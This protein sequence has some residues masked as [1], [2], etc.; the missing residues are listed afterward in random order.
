MEP[1]EDLLGSELCGF[2]ENDDGCE[3]CGDD[4]EEVVH[5]KLERGFEVLV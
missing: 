1:A 3:R 2:T 4:D 5:D